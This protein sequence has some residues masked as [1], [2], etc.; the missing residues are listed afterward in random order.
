[1]YRECSTY[2]FQSPEAGKWQV[3]GALRSILLVEPSMVTLEWF[4]WNHIK[5]QEVGGLR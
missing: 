3:I 5:I 2:I 1:M 4:M